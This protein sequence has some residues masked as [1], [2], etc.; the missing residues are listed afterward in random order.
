MQSSVNT[1]LCKKHRARAYIADEYKTYSDGE[2]LYS[3]A[4][5]NIPFNLVHFV[6][7]RLLGNLQQTF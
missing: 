4:V 5:V 2:L 1:Q 7:Y 6:R 3:A